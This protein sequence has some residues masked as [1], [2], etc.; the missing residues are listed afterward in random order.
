PN[1]STLGQSVTFTATVSSASGTPGGTVTFYSCTN[2][3]CGTKTSL[4]TG[5]LS[6]G[7][8]T[9][10]T[11]SLPVGTTYVEAVFGTSGNYLGSTSTP[12][13]QVVKPMPISTS[14]GL[15]STPNPS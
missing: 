13:A 4:G 10:P 8:A 2:S 15:T 1:P 12:L 3:G 7:K 14:T 6:S 9:L 5:T 11:A